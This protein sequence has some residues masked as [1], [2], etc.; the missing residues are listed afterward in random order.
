M[1]DDLLSLFNA[2]D[3]SAQS[4][5]SYVRAPFGYPGAK[6]RS[7][8]E[9]LP[10]LPQTDKYVEV[11]GGSGAVLLARRESKMEVYNDR[12]GGVV[13]FY[14]CIRD[15]DKL[16]ALTDRLELIVHSRE[17][18]IWCR[19]TWAN[20]EDDVE[21]AARWFYALQTSFTS[22]S[23]N[24]GRSLSGSNQ[25]AKKIQNNIKTFPLVH[26]RLKHVLIEN[27]DWRQCLQDFDD[28]DTVF[29]LDPPYLDVSSGIYKCSFTKSDHAELLERI[30]KLRGFV[31]LSGYPNELYD[32]YNWDV[33]KSWETRVT[34]T[35]N[36]YTETNNQKHGT[37]RKDTAIECLWVK[38]A[39]L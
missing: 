27:L 11:F 38:N 23:R 32:S 6:S 22:Q 14:R 1:S 5:E 3:D 8:K 24:F 29:Y 15:R 34:I 37:D 12:F 33:R 16:Q 9:I 4:R 10:N 36:S 18:F 30:F 31:A 35:A 21:R 7:I 26:E 20:C 13:A 17:E 28:E 39:S 19:D 25:I 2:L